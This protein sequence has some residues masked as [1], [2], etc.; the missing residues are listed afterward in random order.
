MQTSLF[1]LR[2]SSFGM[3]PTLEMGPFLAM[4]EAVLTTDSSSPDRT[5]VDP[6]SPFLSIECAE[7]EIEFGSSKLVKELEYKCAPSGKVIIVI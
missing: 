6:S 7:R 2:A 4:E 5:E 1:H 3:G